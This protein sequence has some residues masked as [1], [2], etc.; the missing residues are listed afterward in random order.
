MSGEAN[1]ALIERFYEEFGQCNG[2]A[3]TACYARDAHFRDPAFGDL[4]DDE[5]GAMWRMLT[6]RAKDLKIELRE[7]EADEE[8]GSA[9]WIA[10]YTFS[11]GRPVVN[12]IQGDIPLRRRP[13][14]RPRRRVRL[15]ALGE[16]GARPERQPRRAAAAAALESP[17]QSA[18]PAGHL[19]AGRDRLEHLATRARPQPMRTCVRMRWDEQRVERDL[20]LPGVGDGTRRPHLRC[21]G[22][23]GDQLPRGPRPLGAQPR[24]GRQL[25]LQLDDQPVSRLHPRLCFLLRPPDAHLSRLRCRP[26]LRARDRRQGQRAGAVAGRAGAADLE[27]GAGRAGDE[28]RSLP[29]GR[30]PLPDDARDPRRPG[31]GG[32]AGLGPDQVAAGAARH[33][34]LRADGEEGCRSRST[35]RSRPSTRRPGGRP[36]RTR[37]ARAP[38]SMRSPSCGGAGSTRGC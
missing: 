2:A 38:A 28:H 15:P 11:T 17:R 18:R 6:G 25:R 34:D 22:G 32:D 1:R 35:S 23:D 31:G 36:S 37:R 9:H 16:A 10:H 14:R 19:Q 30:E 13:D 7:H 4:E 5:I 33:R 12:D 8:S 27:A 26:G 3:M 20:R 24:A 21:A 29:M